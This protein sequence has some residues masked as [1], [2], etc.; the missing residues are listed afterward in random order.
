MARSKAAAVRNAADAKVALAGGKPSDPPTAGKP[1]RRKGQR[2]RMW[3]SNWVRQIHKAQKAT[4]NLVPFKPMSDLIRETA[5]NIIGEAGSVRWNKQALSQLHTEAEQYMTELFERAN[6]YVV[7]SK[8]VT[9]R[10]NDI[11]SAHRDM[12]REA[13]R[14][15]ALI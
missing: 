8:R 11:L 1:P 13:R 5:Q 3:R 4:H 10:S 9:L 12:Q 7:N 6:N 14:L 2:R 15:A